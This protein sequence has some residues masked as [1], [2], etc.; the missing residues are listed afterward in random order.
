MG[1]FSGRVRDMLLKR[2]SQSS[3]VKRDI[4]HP[5]HEARKRDGAMS[6]RA[7]RVWPVAMLAGNH[8]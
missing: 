7:F 1:A 2:R 3:T 8:E 4:F 5:G 6:F